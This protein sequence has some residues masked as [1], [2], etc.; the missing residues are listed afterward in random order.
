[1]QDLFQRLILSDDGDERVGI[2][3]VTRADLNRDK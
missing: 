1:M 2:R 3:F